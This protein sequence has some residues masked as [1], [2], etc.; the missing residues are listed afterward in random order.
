M[1][2]PAAPAEALVGIQRFPDL[3]QPA[4]LVDVEQDQSHGAAFQARQIPWQLDG[5][6]LRDQIGCEVGG[7]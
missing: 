5:P 3:E 4:T 6:M 2:P 1:P 7:S